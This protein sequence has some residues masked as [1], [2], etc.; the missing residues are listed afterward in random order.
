MESLAAVG[1]IVATG[2]DQREQNDDQAK[3]GGGPQI[4]ALGPVERPVKNGHQAVEQ[5]DIDAVK[6]Q[7]IFHRVEF[8]AHIEGSR[9]LIKNKQ[10][11]AG[12]MPEQAG[13]EQ[14]GKLL[15]DH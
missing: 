3:K 6:E 14:P 1:R 13:L 11:P 7:E 8:A 12:K 10:D 4:A 15:Q 2:L 9:L 5:A